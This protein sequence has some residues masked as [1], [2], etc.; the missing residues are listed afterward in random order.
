MKLLVDMKR[1]N[2][3]DGKELWHGW[4]DE[5]GLKEAAVCILLAILF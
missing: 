1:T 2:G 5:S 3:G 4:G